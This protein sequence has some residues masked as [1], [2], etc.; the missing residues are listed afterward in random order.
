MGLE[1]KGEKT[2]TADPEGSK[3]LHARKPVF[4]GI[5]WLNQPKKPLVHPHPSSSCALGAFSRIY[6]QRG[7]TGKKCF[8][9]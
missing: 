2:A 3:V 5:P 4:N 9:P 1:G 7:I 6:R 8:S